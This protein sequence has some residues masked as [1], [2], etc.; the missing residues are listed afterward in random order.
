MCTVESALASVS[1]DNKVSK[2]HFVGVL[3]DLSQPMSNEEFKA[4]TDFLTASI[5]VSWQAALARIKENIAII[6][7]SSIPSSF[8]MSRNSVDSYE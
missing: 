1:V 6:A 5:Q 2:M 7:L 3:A 4:F 8:L